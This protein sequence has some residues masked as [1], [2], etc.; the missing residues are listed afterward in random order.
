[1]LTISFHMQSK[2]GLL[3]NRLLYDIKVGVVKRISMM[4]LSALS[5]YRLNWL[6][7]PNCGS[8]MKRVG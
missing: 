8:K 5:S 2:C 3:L 4:V 1:M 6:A 7:S